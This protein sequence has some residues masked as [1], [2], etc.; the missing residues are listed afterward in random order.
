VIATWRTALLIGL[1]GLL[2]GCVRAVWERELRFEPP[3]PGAVESLQVG[4]TELSDAL[5]ALGAPLWVWEYPEEGGSGAALAWGWYR[6]RNWGG[7]VSIPTNRA[8]SPSFSYRRLDARMRGLVLFFD[9]DWRLVAGREGLLIDL[10][11]DLRRRR[12]SN[13]IDEEPEGPD[14]PEPTAPAHAGSGNASERAHAV[15]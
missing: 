15:L 12:P 14:Q 2:T 10:T 4:R 3:P 13:P 9:P 5:A 6:D 8:L 1:A 7:R 11:R